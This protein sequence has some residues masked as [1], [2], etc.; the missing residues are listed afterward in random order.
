MTNNDASNPSRANCSI[1]EQDV[2]LIGDISF[3]QDVYIKGKITGNILASLDSDG[4]VMIQQ[5][6]IITGE[7]R[8]PN[9]I[10]A[11]KIVGNVFATKR[12]SIANTA[13]IEGD[14]HYGSLEMEQGA[15]I[16]GL[17]VAMGKQ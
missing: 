5:G 16:N 14:I 17:L 3:S 7:V 10:V 12:L 11:G 4:K 2:E 6:G 9:V 15:S 13:L 1:I 8:A